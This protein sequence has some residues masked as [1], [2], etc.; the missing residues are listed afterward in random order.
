M[1]RAELGQQWAAAEQIESNLGSTWYGL[2]E[3]SEL[4][5]RISLQTQGEWLAFMHVREKWGLPYDLLIES[6]QGKKS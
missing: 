1:D 2:A 5:V 4:E 3:S 6:C